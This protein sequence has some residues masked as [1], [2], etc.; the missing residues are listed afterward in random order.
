MTELLLFRESASR[1]LASPTPP[2]FDAEA[3]HAHA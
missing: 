1:L 3:V 2:L